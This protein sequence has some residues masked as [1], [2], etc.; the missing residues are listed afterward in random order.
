MLTE[1]QYKQKLGVRLVLKHC[2][3]G[4]LMGLSIQ[5]FTIFYDPMLPKVIGLTLDCT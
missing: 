4:D 5:P 1:A 2:P 3:K